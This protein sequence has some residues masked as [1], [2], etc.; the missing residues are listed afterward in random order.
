M[1]INFHKCD[2]VPINVVAYNA[3]LFSQALSCKLGEFPMQYLGIPLHHSKLRKEDI[4]PVVDKILKRAAG[5]R[6]KLLNHAT[7][8]ELVREKCSS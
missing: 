8:L 5:W 6:G 3:Q 2:I 4:Q 7:K 1:R